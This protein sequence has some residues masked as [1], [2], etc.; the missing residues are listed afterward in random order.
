[1][2]WHE[3]YLLVAVPV[4]GVP[5]RVANDVVGLLE[6]T[7]LEARMV[8]VGARVRVRGRVEPPPAAPPDRPPCLH[9][10][11]RLGCEG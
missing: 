11:A 2:R 1:M 10:K 8:G 4:E 3:C 9:V 6:R 7:Q 5:P